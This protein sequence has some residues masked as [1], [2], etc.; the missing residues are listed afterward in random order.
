VN[1]Q[2]VCQ[3][4]DQGGLGITNTRIMN[5]ALLVKWIW[6]LFRD[7]SQET[8]WHRIIRAKYPGAADIFASN[9]QGGSPFWRSLHKIKH[10]FKLGAKY[11]VGNDTKI[12]FWMDL[13]IGDAPLSSRFVRLFQ[14]SADPQGFVSQFYR[15][16]T[17]NIRFR[18]SFGVEEQDS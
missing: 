16:G 11:S 15:D 13:W 1:W 8:L 9:A 12:R 4:K 10:Y 7:D 3:P 6:R 17:W 18:R 14:I 5:I 2:E